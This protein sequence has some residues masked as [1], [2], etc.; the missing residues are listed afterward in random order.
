MK[1]GVGTVIGQQHQTTIGCHVQA[2][3]AIADKC[4]TIVWNQKNKIKSKNVDIYPAIV[5]HFPRRHQSTMGEKCPFLRF[6]IQK[7]NRKDAENPK[8]LIR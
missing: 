7:T 2:Q 8:N 6:E 3:K 1:V 5:R 4:D